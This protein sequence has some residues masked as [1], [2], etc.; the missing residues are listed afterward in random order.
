MNPKNV[1]IIIV[2]SKEEVASKVARFGKNNIVTYYDN[3]GNIIIPSE[4]KSAGNVKAADIQKKYADAI[5]G[6]KALNALKDVKM[7]RKG[8]VSQGGQT[9]EITIMSFQ[10]EGNKLKQVVNVDAAGTVMNLQRMV[11][12]GDK[13]T[14]EVRGQKAAMTPEEVA[15]MKEQADMQAELHPEKYGD[16]YAVKGIVQIDGKDAYLVEATDSKG[17]KSSQY[18]DVAT[19]LLIKQV[20]PGEGDNPGEVI[21]FSDYKEVPGANGYKVPYTMKANGG[22]FKITSIDV[23]KGIADKEFE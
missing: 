12:N 8:T 20:S 4:T 6:E 15:E 10:K 9:A 22:E 14:Q 18:Y 11:L 16:K 1:N 7:I 5:G 17:K 23:N 2:G 21:E 19:S 13:G 3:Y